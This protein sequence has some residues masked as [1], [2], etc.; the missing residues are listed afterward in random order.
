MK[1]NISRIIFTRK[2][3]NY[4]FMFTALLLAFGVSAKLNH[5]LFLANSPQINKKALAEL[6]RNAVQNTALNTQ[7]ALGSSGTGDKAL[8]STN[9][10]IPLTS[11]V[12]EIS[13]GV[14]AAEDPVS[15]KRYIIIEKGKKYRITELPYVDN[16]GNSRYFRI[17]D[18]L[19]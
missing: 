10:M 8:D 13:K 16:Q 12:R 9:A 5:D 19:E 4:L 1:K 7:L 3:K 15:G 14:K 17:V 11:V 6:F 18:L 2:M